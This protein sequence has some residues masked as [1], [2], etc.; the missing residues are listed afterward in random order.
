[1]SIRN[2]QED[3]VLEIAAHFFRNRG[4]QVLALGGNQ[5][6]LFSFKTKSGRRKYP[7]L[8]ATRERIT[9]VL[10]A[11]IKSSAL[12][13]RSPETNESDYGALLDLLSSKQAQKNILAKAGL[14]LKSLNSTVDEQMSLCVGLIASDNFEKVRLIAED[15]R[16][17]LIAINT[18]MAQATI[19][20]DDFNIL[21]KLSP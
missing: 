21:K 9:I 3:D 2:V 1:M 6:G 19:V 7:D 13:K 18:E 12:F 11:K 5:A 8:V 17:I 16:V 15:N 10:E 14:V 4:F 20:R